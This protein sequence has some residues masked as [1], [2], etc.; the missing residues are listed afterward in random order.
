MLIL[1][2]IPSTMMAAQ[3]KS[4][5]YLLP[6]EH[7]SAALNLSITAG[8]AFRCCFARSSFLFS[9]L[10]RFAAALPNHYSYFSFA[11]ALPNHYSYFSFAAALPQN[12]TPPCQHFSCFAYI[13]PM[14]RYYPTTSSQSWDDSRCKS[15]VSKVWMEKKQ[16]F[17]RLYLS[18]NQPN[19][20][21][22]G[23]GEKLERY[24][25]PEKKNPNFTRCLV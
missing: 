5:L 17:L 14:T 12:N 6:T 3:G 11:A 22:L 4:V 1:S 16:A 8:L 18:S 25:R 23:F 19:H 2:T 21:S 10:F 15:A 7:K 24:E 20:T 13:C 9:F